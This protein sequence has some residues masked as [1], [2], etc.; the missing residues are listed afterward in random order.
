RNYTSNFEAGTFH[1]VGVVG[2]AVAA[3]SLL[4]LQTRVASLQTEIAADNYA[5]INRESILGDMFY[6]GTLLY[7]AKYSYYTH[8]IK[9]Q[10]HVASELMPSIATIG[11]SMA[12]TYIWGLP[13]SALYTGS[14][15]DVGM[16]ITTSTNKNNLVSIRVLYNLI[17]GMLSSTLE[18]VVLERIL[19]NTTN[20]AWAISTQKVLSLA[21]SSNTPIYQINQSNSSQRIPM[22]TI[23]AIV[24]DEINVALSANKIIIIPENSIKFMNWIG[25]GYIIFDP[26]TGN[27]A[28]RLSGKYNG[29]TSNSCT[30][31]NGG[32]NF[33]AGSIAQVIGAYNKGRY[34]KAADISAKIK[35]DCADM[36]HRMNQLADT[37]KYNPQSLMYVNNLQKDTLEE[38]DSINTG[39]NI[40]ATIAVIVGIIIA[41]IGGMAPLGILVAA[42]SL[43]MIAVR[44]YWLDEAKSTVNNLE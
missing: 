40:V 23:D 34:K 15:V 43:M 35:L 32:C 9:K 5:N 26:V 19:S 18:H 39:L 44:T 12:T 41:S 14:V 31:K 30:S 17:V 7:F 21:L 11:G 8:F 27:G 33:D 10:S 22:L 1:S 37:I 24:L 20:Q 6:A 16:L 13:Y 36:I 42:S 2:G 38:L 4:A 29:G 25:V 3:D 28:Y